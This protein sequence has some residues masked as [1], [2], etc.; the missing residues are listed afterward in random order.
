MIALFSGPIM[1]G[2]K[3]KRYPI[4]KAGKVISQMIV[5]EIDNL[6]AGL[7]GEENKEMD[8]SLFE[9]EPSNY[10]MASAESNAQAWIL[11]QI[12]FRIRPYVAF[13]VFFFEVKIRPI[14]EFRWKRKAPEG[15]ESFKPV[16]L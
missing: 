10:V 11:S 3:I 14:L 9:S 5:N 7:N 2:Q 8:K 12:R 1:A 15:W 16:I 13:D 4:K 6:S